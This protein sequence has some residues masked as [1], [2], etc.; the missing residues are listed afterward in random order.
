MP[1]DSDSPI[2]PTN[3]PSYGT[4]GVETFSQKF[5]RWFS[6]MPD[7]FFQSP[8]TTITGIPP[9]VNDPL[10]PFGPKD[11]NAP[12]A[13][14]WLTNILHNAFIAGLVIL[15]ILGLVVVLDVLSFLPRKR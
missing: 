14:D 11:P 7:W 12:G 10:D 4:G 5:R 8:K 15:G 9:T 3:P 6:F 13:Y 2:I 1:I